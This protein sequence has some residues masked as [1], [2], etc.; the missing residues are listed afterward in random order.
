MRLFSVSSFHLL[1]RSYI[2]SA[3]RVM[4]ALIAGLVAVS[5]IRLGG[6]R[7]NERA[8][9]LVADQISSSQSVMYS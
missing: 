8:R 4:Q 6:M 3:Y 9:Q 5:M 1:R 7:T 2:Q